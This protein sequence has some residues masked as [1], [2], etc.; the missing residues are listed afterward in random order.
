MKKSH[1]LTRET[2]KNKNKKTTIIKT[3][4]KNKDKKILAYNSHGQQQKQ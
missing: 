4:H 1:A 3:K 2:N